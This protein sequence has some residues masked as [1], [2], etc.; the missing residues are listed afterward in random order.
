MHVFT[1]L[2]TFPTHS[3]GTPR[4]FASRHH[5]FLCLKKDMEERHAKG[6]QS[7]PLESGFFY[8]DMRGDVLTPY[9][10]ARVH[11]T[12]FRPVRGVRPTEVPLGYGKHTV[13][14]DSCLLHQLRRKRWHLKNNQRDLNFVVGWLRKSSMFPPSLRTSA[15]TGVAIRFP[16]GT[17]CEVHKTLRRTDCHVAT[18]GSSQ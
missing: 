2:S 6:L 4:V 10:F 13:S 15:H 14:T 18:S 7:R 9:E 1:Y 12:R 16:L 11:F 3:V 5:I 8:W 17:H